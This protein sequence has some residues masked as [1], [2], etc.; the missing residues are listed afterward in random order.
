[1]T[2]KMRLLAIMV[3]F[4]L[5]LKS[6]SGDPAEKNSVTGTGDQTKE[7]FSIT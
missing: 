4:S 7:T 2:M 6:C 5:V 1:M 3:A